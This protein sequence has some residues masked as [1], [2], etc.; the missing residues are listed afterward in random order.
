MS[1]TYFT[2]LL[3]QKIYQQ[4]PDILFLHANKKN[5]ASRQDFL[6]TGQAL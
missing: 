2:Y 3:Q 6:E 5:R 1:Y 4:K